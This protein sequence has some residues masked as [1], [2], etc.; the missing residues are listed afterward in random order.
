MMS[1]RTSTCTKTYVFKLL[2][3][4][5]ISHFH[6]ILSAML[7]TMLNLPINL[8]SFHFLLDEG[9]CKSSLH[10]ERYITRIEHLYDTHCDFKIKKAANMNIIF[11][12]VSQSH[13]NDAGMEM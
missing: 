9:Q 13:S 12:L 8:S 3:I 11:T 10:S 2:I 1:Y 7:Y 4:V 6:S 5:S